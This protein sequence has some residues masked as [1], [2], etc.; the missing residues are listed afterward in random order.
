MIKLLSCSTKPFVSPKSARLALP[1]LSEEQ[2]VMEAINDNP[3]V[4]LCGETGSGK[5]T[6]LPQFLYE[7]GYTKKYGGRY[8]VSDVILLLGCAIMLQYCIMYIVY[9]LIGVTEPRRVA[10]I[11]MSSRVA[12]EMNLPSRYIELPWRWQPY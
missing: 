7:A 6:Q 9:S 1:I 4:I 12:L 10:A 11:S 2:E 5:T 8:V 3:V